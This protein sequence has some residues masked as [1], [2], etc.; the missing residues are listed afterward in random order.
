MNEKEKDQANYVNSILEN[1]YKTCKEERTKI[2]HRLK[3]KS[4]EYEQENR[5]K[6]QSRQKILQIKQQH[7]ERLDKEIRV[8]IGS[9]NR[10]I[11][12]GNEI[13]EKKQEL[14]TAKEQEQKAQEALAAWP[15]IHKILIDK[16]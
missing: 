9:Q 3:Q 2:E 1:N 12:I 11:K 10:L 8:H 6:E 13:K 15:S 14:Q 5:L 7:D 4:Q 16:N